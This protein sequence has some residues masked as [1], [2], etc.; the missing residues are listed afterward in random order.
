MG[1]G[2]FE[3]IKERVGMM[4]TPKDDDSLNSMVQAMLDAHMEAVR[5]AQLQLSP[6]SPSG[7][8]SLSSP[9]WYTSMV[10]GN[11]FDSVA[12]EKPPSIDTAKLT[13]LKAA[14]PYKVEA[15]VPDYVTTITAWRAWKVVNQGGLRL[16]ALGVE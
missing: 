14:Q 5:Y 3:Q 12:P 15:R 16:K 8:V 1:K 11:Y 7:L 2:L 13:A 6:V 9:Q 4:K 10:G